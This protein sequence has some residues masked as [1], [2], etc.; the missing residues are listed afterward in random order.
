MRRLPNK[1]PEPAAVLSDRGLG[2]EAEGVLLGPES[3]VAVYAASWR[4]A[5]FFVKRMRARFYIYHIQFV[6]TVFLLAG[7]GPKTDPS[8][9]FV[10]P[11]NFR[12]IIEITCD[13]NSG[14]ALEPK[15]GRCSIVVPADGKVRVA[16]FRVFDTFHVV[17][18]VSASGVAIPVEVGP[19]GDSGVVALHIPG[20]SVAS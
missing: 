7:C 17:T 18:A 1:S 13:T 11:N 12:G 6:F 2:E 5:S 8:M 15:N 4:W 19:S 10:L 14:I 20:K 9:R 16:S 3:D